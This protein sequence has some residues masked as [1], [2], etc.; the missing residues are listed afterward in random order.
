[1]TD[2]PQ[3]MAHKALR[4]SIVLKKKRGDHAMIGEIAVA[5]LIVVLIV[6]ASIERA[7]DILKDF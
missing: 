2:V 5:A 6:V 3:V 4:N 1:M 7:E